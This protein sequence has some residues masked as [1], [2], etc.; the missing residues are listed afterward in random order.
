M[1][2]SLLFFLT[3][4][5]KI[6][7][8]KL[9]AREGLAA[10]GNGSL[11]LGSATAEPPHAALWGEPGLPWHRAFLW[12]RQAPSSAHVGSAKGKGVLPP[13]APPSR[14]PG[15]GTEVESIV[16]TRDWDFWH[17]FLFGRCSWAIRRL[18]YCLLGRKAA[19]FEW[20]CSS[21]QSGH[22]AEVQCRR[23]EVLP[24]SRAK[25]ETQSSQLSA[26]SPP[27]LKPLQ[28]SSAAV[29]QRWGLFCNPQVARRLLHEA[30]F[31][32]W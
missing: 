32:P 26:L 22:A 6:W 27:A 19:R 25:A 16:W 18:L 12:G 28:R 15:S 9:A 10:G 14:G 23:T 8:N 29:G 30:A 7:A 13:A 24:S 2:I 11:G 20:Q 17:L 1:L 5:V 4:R 31:S 3:F 21:E